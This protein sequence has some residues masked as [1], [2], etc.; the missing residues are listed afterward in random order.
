MGNLTAPAPS[1]V[2]IVESDLIMRRVSRASKYDFSSNL[3]AML[4][5]DML[6]MTDATASYHSTDHMA[7]LLVSKVLQKEHGTGIKIW[8]GHPLTQMPVMNDRKA[9]GREEG[10]GRSPFTMNIGYYR[11]PVYEGSV[12]AQQ[13]V[14]V[15]LTREARLELEEYFVKL[16]HSE[17]PLYHLMGARGTYDAD[18]LIIKPREPVFVDGQ[19]IDEFAE[20]F[21]NPLLPPTADRHS[22]AGDG[23]VTSIDTLS[24]TDRMDEATVRRVLSNMITTA[25]PL[26]RVKLRNE[27]T[28]KTQIAPYRLWLMPEQMFEDL[29][30]SLGSDYRELEA[31][32][33]KRISGYGHPVFAEDCIY[34][35][36]CFIVP[37]AKPVQWTEG[38]TVRVSGPD[39][40]ATVTE[41][42]VPAG[43][44]VQRSV[45]IGG[46]ALALAYGGTTDGLTFKRVDEKD[47]YDDRDTAC[48]AWMGGFKAVRQWTSQGRAYDM[49][50]H[51][52]DAAVAR[53]D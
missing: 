28:K 46:R 50:R 31:A 30:E 33:M 23:S 11:K 4:A 9:K 5:T 21:A 6:E 26:S 17:L 22:F 13:Q 36:G 38:Q 41:Q 7:P 29:R 15:P 3:A 12:W 53:P 48:L 14:G 1:E 27:D 44:T 43:V 49:G 18:D 32:A 19:P 25:Y 10:I 39:K 34:I 51:I 24:T 52:V 2:E 35:K 16:F 40:L 45:I 47:D 8:T 42:T 20:T 37:M